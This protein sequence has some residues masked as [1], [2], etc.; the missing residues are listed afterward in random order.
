MTVYG[1]CEN[2]CKAEVY[3]KSQSD[4]NISNI[5]SNIVSTKIDLKKEMKTLDSEL[6]E[7]LLGLIVP[8]DTALR[9]LHFD[10][11]NDEK[12]LAQTKEDLYTLIDK[13]RDA[14]IEV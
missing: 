10:V 13:L 1:I 6:K 11:K 14:G 2:K 3:S 4:I 7:E 12:I 9:S 5:N 8:I